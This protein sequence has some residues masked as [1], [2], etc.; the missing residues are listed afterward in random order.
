MQYQIIVQEVKEKDDDP[1][2]IYEARTGNVLKPWSEEI[3]IY[4]IFASNVLNY[5]RYVKTL[6]NAAAI[7]VYRI[8]KNYVK[9]KKIERHLPGYCSYT[10]LECIDDD[11]KE[12]KMELSASTV[13]FISFH[14]YAPAMTTNSS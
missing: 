10:S 14:L 5:G 3:V 13:A 2:D 8:N 4:H 12:Y 7:T 9:R 1:G 11:E 6:K